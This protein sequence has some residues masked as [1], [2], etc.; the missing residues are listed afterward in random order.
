MMVMMMMMM[1]MMMMIM[2]MMM[3]VRV[4]KCPGWGEPLRTKKL[5]D[6][7]STRLHVDWQ[8][9][10]N[11][12]TLQT[13]CRSWWQDGPATMQ[14]LCH[15]Q[16]RVCCAWTSL[17]TSLTVALAT[18]LCRCI[19]NGEQLGWKRENNFMHSLKGRSSLKLHAMWTQ[20][21]G[22]CSRHC[23]RTAVLVGGFC[24][25]LIAGNLELGTRLKWLMIASASGKCWVLCVESVEFTWRLV[26]F[27]KLCFLNEKNNHYVCSPQ[28]GED[29]RPRCVHGDLME[30]ITES[31]R[32]EP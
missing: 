9:H 10:R 16:I 20:C 24:F 14:E 7:R 15:C 13:I 21:A 32:T 6:G 17:W 19:S 26:F 23:R 25:L 1:L 31:A 12:Q 18:V 5:L 30:R 8:P 3:I 11:G 29:C 28:V 2:M 27:L 22:T 4:E